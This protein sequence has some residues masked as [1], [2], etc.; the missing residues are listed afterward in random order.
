M[1][2]M[3]VNAFIHAA[4]VCG[5]AFCLWDFLG[6]KNGWFICFLLA[7]FFALP[8]AGENA[9]WAIN[10]Q[11][12]SWHFFAGDA[13]RTG[14]WQGRAVCVGGSGLAAA[15]MGSFTMASG[16]L[17]PMAVGGLAILRTIKI[18]PDGKG[19]FDHAGCLSGGHG[20]GPGPERSKMEED[21]HLRAHTLM[22]FASALTRNLT[23]PFF[24]AP[25]MACLILLPLVGAGWLYFRPDF[26]GV[27]RG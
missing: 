16:L 17:A 5:L 19:K 11:N 14:V 2:Q 10:S 21:Q 25:E 6:R 1:L 3:T 15:I 4:Y 23:W 12:I 27:A 8:Y 26:P 13:G 18:P 7:P 24:S 22:E 20:V 9:I